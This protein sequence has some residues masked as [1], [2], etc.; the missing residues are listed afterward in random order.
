M[1]QSI[2]DHI[3]TY[4][5]RSEFLELRTHARRLT[6]ENERLRHRLK[7]YEVSRAAVVHVSFE[8]AGGLRED[9]EISV[10]GVGS[11]A[12]LRLRLVQL[13]DALLLDPEDEL[14]E[15]GVR[16]TDRSGRLRP[17]PSRGSSFQNAL[18]DAQEIRVTAGASLRSSPPLDGH[19]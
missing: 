2:P 7:G 4:R 3:D 12:Q 6:D 15:M 17:L 14:G 9:G 1:T 18:S 10:Q 16:Y 19:G 5:A 11:M 8:L 13:A